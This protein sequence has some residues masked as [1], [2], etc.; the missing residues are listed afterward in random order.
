MNR[1]IA[2]IVALQ[3]FIIV[4]LFWLLVFYGKDEYEAATSDHDDEIESVSH[5][6]TGKDAGDGAATI[7]LSPASQQ[8]SGLTTTTLQS[9]AYQ[10]QA[11]YLGT[12]IGIEPLVELRTRYLSARADAS[13][14]RA[15]L[16]NS[17]QEHQ[18]LL[19]LNGDNKN[20]SDRAVAIAEAA[21]KSDQA[22]VG[23]ADAAANNVRDNIRQ[24]WGNT[25]AD[26]AT[27]ASAKDPF[28]RLLQSRDVLLQIT[29]PFDA[30]AP[31]QHASLLVEPMGGQGQA[32][33]AT[34]ISASPQTDGTIQGKTYYYRAPAEVLRAGMRVT[35]RFASSDK[36]SAG[37]IVPDTAV[38]WYANQAWVY[39]KE[40]AEKFVR[41]QV[42]T[43]IEV[44][45]KSGIG[46]FNT[47][48]G[49]KP[50][51]KVVSS[52]AQLLLSEEFKYQITNENDD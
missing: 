23:A 13:L 18:R 2:I 11:S 6:V 19:Q 17:Q 49:L 30:S 36:R 5:V 4:V 52:G 22:R 3:A 46:W 12:V 43:D 38:V 9:A 16:S 41:R 44:D 31:D 42:N 27:D 1:K 51:D 28:Q 32:S 15:S 10:A 37:V 47:S 8:Q 35:A 14:A 24:Q 40:S 21:L 25:L 39:Q 7:N 20:V 34:F 50:G 33:K 29:L 48:S 26:W 45:S